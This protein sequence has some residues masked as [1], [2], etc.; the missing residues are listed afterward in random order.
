MFIIIIIHKA[1]LFMIVHKT[2]FLSCS[3][4]DLD[5]I[6]LRTGNTKLMTDPAIAVNICKFLILILMKY[7]IFFYCMIP[8]I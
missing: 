1:E 3:L 5:W 2:A 7:P 8:L 6:E 4:I